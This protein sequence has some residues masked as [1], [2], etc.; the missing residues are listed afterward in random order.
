MYSRNLFF[1]YFNATLPNL[2]GNSVFESDKKSMTEVD[3]SLILTTPSSIIKSFV[4]S[5][6]DSKHSANKFFS[7]VLKK[8]VD[9][10][11]ISKSYQWSGVD[12][13]WSKGILEVHFCPDIR[14]E[15]VA[16]TK[17]NQN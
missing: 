10:N 5:Q 14:L 7:I 16:L 8:S 3:G 1:V 4:A 12:G 13:G 11:S 17:L 6:L 9:I 2:I 15:T